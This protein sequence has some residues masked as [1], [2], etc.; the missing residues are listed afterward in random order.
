[1]NILGTVMECCTLKWVSSICSA[2]QSSDTVK[3]TFN[4]TSTKRPQSVLLQPAP[5]CHNMTLTIYYFLPIWYFKSAAPS[6]PF[7][8]LYPTQ[9]SYIACDFFSLVLFL[10]WVRWKEYFQLKNPP[11]VTQAHRHTR[12]HTPLCVA[13]TLW[14]H[15]RGHKLSHSHFA[16]IYCPK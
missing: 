2:S 14:D 13:V 11:T 12:V 15:S 6:P 4:F 10:L 5:I 8:C 1:M 3:N 9:S 16:C 7:V